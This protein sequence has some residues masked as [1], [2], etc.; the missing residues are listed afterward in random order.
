M[1]LPMAPGSVHEVFRAFLKLG[2]TSFGGPIAHI[3][4]QRT[5]FVL[6][7]KWLDED[8]FAQLL[9]VCQFLPGPSSSQMGFAMGLFRAGKWGALAAFVGFTVP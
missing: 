2:L 8:Q 1:S 6:R 9:V 3:S 7:R 5:E 4:Y